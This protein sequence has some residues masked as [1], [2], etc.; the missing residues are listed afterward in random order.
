MHVGLL[1]NLYSYIYIQFLGV[2]AQFSFIGEVAIFLFNSVIHRALGFSPKVKDV[3][4][5]TLVTT[6]T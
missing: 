1:A 6:S 2:L 5:S 3:L 4:I